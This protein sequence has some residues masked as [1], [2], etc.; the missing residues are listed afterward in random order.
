[1]NIKIS[2]IIPVYNVEK[3]LSQCIE[4]LLFQDYHSLEVILIND[5]S[6][7]SSPL[8]CDRFANQ[9]DR[10][11]VIHKNNGGP[12]SARN[13]G[14]DN[15]TGDYICFVDSDDFWIKNRLDCIVKQINNTRCDL[16]M[17]PMVSYYDSSDSYQI[18]SKKMNIG[19]YFTG[20]SNLTEVLKNDYAFGWCPVRFVINK[21]I[22]NKD[23]RFMEGYLCEDVDFVFRLWNEVQTVD[24]FTDNVYAY[25]REQEASITHVA[26]Y[27]FSYDLL[28]MIKQNLSLFEHYRINDDL[29]NLLYLNFQDLVGV[30]LYWYSTY[31][32]SQK[33]GLRESIKE[34]EY[35]FTLDSNYKHYA[36]KKTKTVKFLLNTFGINATGMAWGVKR[37]ITKINS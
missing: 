37:K 5:G 11:I 13:I 33:K 2:F 9:D 3:Y 6:T 22:L 16:L 19:N 29:K 15:A 10:I 27:K 31:S 30:V 35:I 32:K 4:S 8:I 21:N 12:S 18:F 14:I 23:F 25:R 28:F 1:M 17:I 34:I 24:Y 20:N 26:S 36:T 7:D